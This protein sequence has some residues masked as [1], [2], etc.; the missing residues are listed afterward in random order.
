MI[1]RLLWSSVASDYVKSGSEWLPLHVPD[2]SPWLAGWL[3]KRGPNFHR[4]LSGES[5][6]SPLPRCRRTLQVFLSVYVAV[7][8]QPT[9]IFPRAWIQMTSDRS[10]I[11][12]KNNGCAG[13]ASAST[14]LQLYWSKLAVCLM[15]SWNMTANWQAVES[16]S[17]RHSNSSCIRA[18]ALHSLYFVCF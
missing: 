12:W 2:N 1:N 15:T 13:L 5:P 9:T 11:N 18:L 16:D 10:S 4:Q 17:A 8:F 6:N 3:S 7:I 14:V